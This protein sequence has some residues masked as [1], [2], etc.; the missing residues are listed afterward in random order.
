V[1]GLSGALVT[2]IDREDLYRLSRAI[3]DILDDLRDFSREWDLY[4]LP[5]QEM[6]QPLLDEALAA[7]RAMGRAAR[8]IA[9]DPASITEDALKA[10]KS[11]NRIRR[12]YQYA[13]ADLLDGRDAVVTVEMLKMREL[14]RRLD[15][16]GMRIT[17]AAD[18]LADAAVKRSH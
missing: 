17:Q 1:D 7:L 18:V 10:K 5:G 15:I 14:L 8:R 2:P 6:F 11:G 4:G 12:S 9:T 16:V 13:I 3:D